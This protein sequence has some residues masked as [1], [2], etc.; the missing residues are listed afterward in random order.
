MSRWHCPK[1]I[2]VKV[3]LKRAET[4]RGKEREIQRETGGIAWLLMCG[5]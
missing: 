2:W 5:G 3:F 4:E 1:A